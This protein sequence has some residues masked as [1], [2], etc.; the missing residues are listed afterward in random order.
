[1]HAKGVGALVV[2]EGVA[3]SCAVPSVA[4]DEEGGEFGSRP[5]ERRIPMDMTN[6]ML[7]MLFG[8]I[9]SGFLTYG[10][11]AAKILPMAVGLA[12][13]VCPYFIGN[14]AVMAGVCVSLAAVPFVVRGA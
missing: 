8:L 11:K 9:G 5:A 4:A 1:M 14:V 6:L 13:I 12:L 7:S 3:N 10:K 2:G